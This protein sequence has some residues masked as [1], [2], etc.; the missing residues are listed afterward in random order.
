MSQNL[1]KKQAGEKA[2][3][4]VES[5]MT[6]GLGTGSTTAFAIAALGRRVREE[7]LFIK[8]IPT[9]SSAELEARKQGVPICTFDD[10]DGTLDI[11]VDGA[12]EVS[13]AL[14][15]I[16]GRGAAHTREKLVASQADRFIV[17]VDT[18]KLVKQLGIKMPVPIEVIPMAAPV[19][20]GTLQVMGAAAALRLGLRKDG[21]IVS[22]QGFWIIDA[23]FGPISDP[24][25]L[26]RTLLEMPGVLDHGLFVGLATE[27]IVGTDTGVEVL[28]RKP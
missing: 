20:L 7:G 23:Q 9:S 22:D 5:G 18:S 13:P 11:A 28:V 3:Q 15:L 26:S 21:P 6:V 14:D 25:A 27:V 16:K 4:C 1:A 10:I 2:A 17:L 19:V 24:A 12:D 8:G